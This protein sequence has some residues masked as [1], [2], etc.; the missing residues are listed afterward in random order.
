MESAGLPDRFGA[1]VARLP[2][3]FR[4]RYDAVMDYQRA[5]GIVLRRQPIMETTLIVTWF[6]REFGKL[7]TIAKGARRPKSPFAG[8]LDLFYQAELVF[9]PS[10][11][12]DLHLLHECFL[13]DARARLRES[14][15]R[16][17][18]A[19]YACELVELITPAEQPQPDLAGLLAGALDGLGRATD[20]R[21]LLLW[22]ELR[23]L[24]AAGWKPDWPATSGIG[25]VLHSLLT[26]DVARA[27]RVRLSET[28][29]AEAR[30]LVWEFWNE[31]VG[32]APRSRR[33]LG[34]ESTT[35]ALTSPVEPV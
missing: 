25:R 2:G 21:V 31:Q 32:Q 35:K 18:A 30:G 10:R 19:S 13:E 8:K 29:V 23:L 16:L 6:T 3:Q 12:S 1:A 4:K 14:V 22:L 28:H 20:D 5:E 27:G 17:T 9:L 33:F 24:T 34:R 15:A 11:R 7:K 26:A